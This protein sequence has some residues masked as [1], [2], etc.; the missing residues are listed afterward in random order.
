MHHSAEPTPPQSIPPYRNSHADQTSTPHLRSSYHATHT[1]TP[2]LFL[3]QRSDILHLRANPVPSTE[4]RPQRARWNCSNGSDF[5]GFSDRELDTIRSRSVSKVVQS[6]RKLPITA[7]CDL[8]R[9]NSSLRQSNLRL[10]HGVMVATMHKVA[11]GNGYEYYMRQTAANDKTACGR[12]SLSDYYNEHGEAPGTWYG[13]GLSA[14][15]ITEGSEVTEDQMKNLFGAGMHPNAEQVRERVK[16]Q[17]LD[18]GI[19][20]AEAARRAEN[21]TKLGNRYAVYATV[22][23]YRQAKRQAYRDYNTDAGACVT[24]HIPDDIRARIRATVATAMF[25]TEYNRPPLDARELS[26]WIAKNSRPDRA[27]VAGYDFTFSAVKSISV[28]WAIGTPAIRAIIETAIRRAANDALTWMEDNALFTRLGRNGVRQ[29]DVQGMIA[30]TFEHRDSRAGDPDLHIHVLV[31]NRVLTSDGKWRTI[32]GKTLHESTVTASEIFDTRLEHH[33]EIAL[34]IRFETR[35]DRTPDQVRVRDIVGVPLELIHHWSRRGAAITDR[36][37]SLTAKWQATIGHEPGPG[38]IHR[39]A[40]RATLETRPKKHVPG[41]RTEQWATWRAEAEALLGGPD[42]VDDILPRVL[43]AVPMPRPVPDRMFITHIADQALAAVSQRRATWRE[44]NLRAEVERQLRGNVAPADWSRV[45]DEVVTQSL[46]PSAAL[47]R[48]DP[49]VTEEPDLRAVPTWLRRRD[50]TPMH[51]R[52]NSRIY[53]TEAVLAAEAELIA[54]SI[55]PGGRILNPTHI[56]DAVDEYN[57]AHPD[58]PLKPGQVRVIESFANAGLRVHAANAP[59]GTGKTTAMQV[60]STAWR[61][62]G[63]TVLG[64]A[65]TA[66]A[67]SVLGESIGTRAET[68]DK[69]LHVIDAHQPG[70]IIGEYLPFLP[71]WVLDIDDTTLVIVDEHVTLPTA[72]RLQLLRYLTDRGAT[73]RCIGDDQQLPAIDAGGVDADMAHASPQQTPTLTEVVRFA[74]RGEALASKGLREG[75]PT[76]LAW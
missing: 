29:V 18:A 43:A 40:Q 37:D 70:A 12:A 75:D 25:T 69:L 72:K 41:S 33:L 30:A 63:G 62:S 52:A 10:P 6:C 57:S 16:A 36:L 51:T 39:L 73:V 47:A 9:I 17:H 28:L 5:Q 34:G 14:L 15:G 58:Q 27:A 7:K 8:V 2:T 26:G 31:S 22:S 21:A 64:M 71:Q 4:N 24:A 76:A 48:G 59:A 50:G 67:A 68:V 45:T 42:A 55:E 35:P 1:P 74:H 44:F 54:L 49:D 65:P 38:D 60:L 61:S 32:D 19:R 13:T 56:L 46:S 23:D 11:A 20:P 66:A 3:L 53:T